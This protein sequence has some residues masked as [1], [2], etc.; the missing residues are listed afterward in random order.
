MSPIETTSQQL[1]PELLDLMDHE[2]VID[3][4]LAGFIEVGNALLAIR[5]GKKYRAAGYATFETY[6]QQR[7]G[8]NRSRSYQLMDAA[9]VATE[10]STNVD[11]R[12]TREAQVRPLASLPDP[13]ERAAAWAEAVEAADGGQPTARLVEEAVAKRQPPKKDHPAPFS[14]AIL[15]TVTQQLNEVGT[16]A[17]VV[18][19]FAGI[20][21]VHELRERAGVEHTI[22]VELEPEWAAKHPDTMQGNALTLTEHVGTEAVDAIVTSPTYGNRMAD[23]HNATDDSIRLTY[24]HTLGHDLNDD[25]SGAMQWGEQYRDFHRK[26]WAEAVAALR[27]GGTLTLNCKN[28]VR[29]GDIQRVTEWHINHLMHECGLD[30]V[31]CDV[32]PTR[33]LMAGANHDARTPV[34]HVITFRK[35]QRA[36]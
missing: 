5:D 32:V 7:W 15:N 20:G 17:T 13:T 14:D 4:G 9:K 27:P 10:M 35:P 26:A 6:C 33:G 24:K 2:K 21:R 3:Q 34:E 19:P 29:G 31:A 22:G 12:P 23:H 8:I 25:N 28:H 11:I 30:I 18:D 16:P 36:A 1:T